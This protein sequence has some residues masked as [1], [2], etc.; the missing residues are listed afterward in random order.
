L[1]Q[2]TKTANKITV[3]ALVPPQLRALAAEGPTQ[4]KVG[5]GRVIFAPLERLAPKA[6][7]KFRIRVQGVEEGDQRIR[8]QVQSDEMDSPVTKEESTNVY[9]DR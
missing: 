3:A 2:G 7:A 1:N 4:S 8:V 9:A 5:A 6:D